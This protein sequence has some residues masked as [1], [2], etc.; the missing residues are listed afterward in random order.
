LNTG[1]AEAGTALGAGGGVEVG[2]AFGAGSAVGPGAAL[3][4]GAALD[5]GGAAEADAALPAG[6]AAGAGA[7]LEVGAAFEVG[8]AEEAGGVFEAGTPEDAGAAPPGRTVAGD[9]AG[10]PDRDGGV[11]LGTE[12]CAGVA[13]GDA[14]AFGSPAVPPGGEAAGAAESAWAERWARGPGPPDPSASRAGRAAD[15]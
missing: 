14:G 6:A 9:R 3:V 7:A 4:A 12:V 10:G 2:A 11:A 1:G 8:A 5:T 15:A 13:R